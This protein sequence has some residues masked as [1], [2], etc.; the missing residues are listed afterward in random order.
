LFGVQALDAH[1]RARLLAF[2]AIAR[3]P[4][5]HWVMVVPRG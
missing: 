2:P 5:N 1:G 3:C 4:S